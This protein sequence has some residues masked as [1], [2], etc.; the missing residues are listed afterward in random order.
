[1]TDKLED[2]DDIIELFADYRKGFYSKENAI[3]Q[4]VKR[5]FEP[6]LAEAML[7]AMRKNNVIDIRGYDKR[8]KYLKD[9]HDKWRG[10]IRSCSNKPSGVEEDNK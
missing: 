7:N 3:R 10:A 4:M 5:G 9:A 8:P 1:M 2:H 6:H